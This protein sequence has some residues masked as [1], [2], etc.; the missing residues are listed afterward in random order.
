MTSRLHFISPTTREKI[1]EKFALYREDPLFESLDIR[2]KEKS[3]V[4]LL[5]RRWDE[6][7][8]SLKALNPKHQYEAIASFKREMPCKTP[9]P[10]R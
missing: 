3:D 10:G 9:K 4:T 5:L 7:K 2:V 6:P 8:A 1:I